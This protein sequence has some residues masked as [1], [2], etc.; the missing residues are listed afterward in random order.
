MSGQVAETYRADG[1]EGL[2]SRE[3][4]FPLL[5]RSSSPPLYLF[6]VFEI[7]FLCVTLTVLELV[8]WTKL[9]L[10]FTEIH[11]LGLKVCA[12]TALAS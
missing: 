6:W 1:A 3:S 7:A 2:C 9:A 10:N 5:L 11:L 12:T 4:I 8:L